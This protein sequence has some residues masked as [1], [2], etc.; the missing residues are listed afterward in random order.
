[1]DPLYQSSTDA[2]DSS[3]K[4]GT[5]AFFCYKPFFLASVSRLESAFEPATGTPP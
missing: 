4:D 5:Y 1:M 2:L 3:S